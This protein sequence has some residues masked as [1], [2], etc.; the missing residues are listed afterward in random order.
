MHD[1]ANPELARIQAALQDAA[2]D[3]IL[4]SSLANVTY[5]SGLDVPIPQG[6]QGE[7]A[8]GPALA[9]CSARENV[10]WL[11][12]PNFHLRVA[13]ERSRLNEVLAFDTFD[14]F[15]A[16]SSEQSY[17]AQLEVALRRA[18]LYG[19]R[20]TL[21]VEKRAL[22]LAVSEWLAAN[23]PGIRLS[24]VRA[25][26][27]HARRI[28]TAREVELIRRAAKIT[29]IGSATLRQLARTPGLDEFEM[30]GAMRGAMD[31]A[32][33]R[34]IPVVGELV[35]GARTAVVAYPGG[36]HARETQ[37]GDGV[38]TDI[39]VR[40][41]GGYW[42]DIANTFIVGAV[43]PTAHQ[44]KFVRASREAFEAAVE[45]L[46][47]GK[48]ASDVFYAAE[49]ALGQ[50]GLEMAHYAGHQVGVTVNE[51]PLLVPYDDTPLEA[52]MVFSVEPGAYEGAGG[53]FGARHERTVLV[54]TT[55]PELLSQ[56]QWGIPLS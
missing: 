14:S 45:C 56:F 28:K 32:A 34:E 33:G 48:R 9:L 38:V 46:R 16:T 52:G 53:S 22:P 44:K 37:R 18:G 6:S 41:P 2:C 5:V 42:A 40:A 7:L 35:T 13:Q 1:A 4:L 11:I 49:R 19:S 30:W 26:L 8:Y 51:P 50:H 31:R 12:I 47:P 17:L 27:E 43:E 29:D 24:D 10:G 3:W 54:T 25:G 20:A 55:G 39:S 36:P 21:G 23:C 15:A